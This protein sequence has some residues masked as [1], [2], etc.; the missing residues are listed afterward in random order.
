MNDKKFLV[1]HF[2]NFCY[3]ISISDTEEASD[4]HKN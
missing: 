4:F 2:K 1:Q 3:Q